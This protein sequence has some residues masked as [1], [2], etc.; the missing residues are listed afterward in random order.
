MADLQGVQILG[1]HHEG[2]GSAN[3]GEDVTFKLRCTNGEEEFDTQF[4]IAHDQLPILLAHL[5]T[6]GGM[7]RNV[8]LK[9]NPHEEADGSYTSNMAMIMV[10]VSGGASLTFPDH[11]VLSLLCD[12][13]HGRR[14]PAHFSTDV[15]GLEKLKSQCIHLLKA[16]RQKPRPTPS[17]LN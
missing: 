9:R 13:G 2:G 10:D 12:V 8:R 17:G 16:L 14:L 6:F 1:I 4:F 7:A 3:K 15:S 5:V 11:A